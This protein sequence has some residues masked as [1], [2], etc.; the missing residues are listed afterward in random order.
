MKLIKDNKD[1]IEEYADQDDLL[2]EKLGIVQHIPQVTSYHERATLENK[3]ES[4]KYM[5]NLVESLINKRSARGKTVYQ[6]D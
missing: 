5:S 3:E 6:K 1:V 2:K 4:V